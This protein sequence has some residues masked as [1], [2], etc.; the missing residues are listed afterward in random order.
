MALVNHVTTPRPRPDVGLGEWAT[1]PAGSGVP[2]AEPGPDG[3]L[4]MIRVLGVDDS[5]TAALNM[6]PIAATDQSVYVTAQVRCS[7]GLSLVAQVGSE[8]SA[9][10]ALPAG[11][12]VEVPLEHFVTGSVSDVTVYLVTHDGTDPVVLPAGETLDLTMGYVSTDEAPLIDGYH[13]FDG[14]T[15]DVLDENGRGWV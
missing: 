4:G 15:P 14:G 10:V 1:V 3:V 7:V 5:V 12:W 13:Y 9:P 6:V 2:V 8:S 11:E